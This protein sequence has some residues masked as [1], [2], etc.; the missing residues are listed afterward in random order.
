MLEKHFDYRKR[1]SELYQQWEKAGVFKMENA[2]NPKAPAFTIA[3]PPPNANGELHI[4]HSYGYSVMD[5]LGR[6]HRLMGAPVLLLPGKDHAGIQ[7]Q[8]VFEKKLRAEGVEV[9]KMPRAEFYKRCYDFCVD[10]AQYMRAQEKSLGISADWD[11]E[12]FTLD[13]RISKIVYQT[14]KKMYDDGLVYKGSRIVHWSVYSQTAISDVEVE[15]REEPGNLWHIAYALV[16]TVKQ[17]ERKSF[18]LEELGAELVADKNARKLLIANVDN[19]NISNLKA[20]DLVLNGEE[21]L[22]VYAVKKIEKIDDEDFSDQIKEKLSAEISAGG[23]AKIV[24][25]LV[26]ALERE[27]V[28][29]MATTRPETMLGDTAIAVNPED[30]R[31]THLLGK[32]VRIPIA[33][34]EIKILADKRIDITYGTGAVKVTP[35]HDFVDYEIGIDHKLEQI[36]VID[37]F[38]KMTALVPEKFRSMDI[39]KCREEIVKELEQS[40]ELLKIE[41]IKHMV[42]IAERGKDIIEPLI[43]EQWFV[44]V[45]KKGNSLRKRALELVNSGRINVFPERLK[46]TFVQWLENLR[47]WNI[48]RQILWG[49]QMPVWYKNRGKNNEEIYVD[50]EA[51]KGEGWVQE[52][53]TFDTWFSSGQWSY[54][55]FAS[56]GLLDLDNPK[57]SPYF[58]NHTMQ[59]GRDILF[60]WACRMILFA[61]YR[62]NDIPWKNIYFTGLIRDQHGQKMSKSKGNG[63]EPTEMIEKYGVDA[64]RMSFIAGNKAGVDVKFSEKKVEGYAKFVNKLWNAAKLTELKLENKYD[65]PAP[66]FKG[67]KLQSSK[68]IISELAKTNNLMIEEMQKYNLSGALENVYQF[69]WDVFCSWYL[70]IVKIQLANPALEAAEIKSVLQ[71]VLKRILIMLHAFA[72]FVTEEIFQQMHQFGAKNL[73]AVDELN[74][75]EFVSEDQKFLSAFEIISATR[76]H[77][78][79]LNLNFTDKLKIVLDFDLDQECKLLVEEMG[80]V[81]FVSGLESS[82]SKPIKA[83]KLQIEAAGDAK[84]QYLSKIQKQLEELDKI[85]TVEE[86]RL[87][88]DFAKKAPEE[89]VEETRTS[90]N[91]NKKA[92]EILRSEIALN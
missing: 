61:A 63:I 64:L 44:S 66:D 54:S 77:R 14:F 12:I 8:V 9:E 82:I 34:R 3:M 19:K 57:N 90:C 92:A 22:L 87:N 53:D 46:K 41:P 6:F 17:P 76:E 20:G 72:P 16:D 40:G 59:M 7:T 50:L 10:R 65:Y 86:G 31:Y 74:K 68:W 24:A 27:D 15:Y 47:D 55:T 91:R 88:S 28:V 26:P 85:I 36:Q 69:T 13:P 84:K 18:V 33:D 52:T 1:E 58:P 89:L 83:G 60:F 45:D 39:L 51:P 75:L 2:R 80:K 23:G 81:E 56:L 62:M 42:P 73:L 79:A 11:K 78:K 32:K 70:E 25:K 29:I 48:S 5:T 35:A 37:K 4:G 30:P 49:H 71:F 43:S 67:L 21:K 38:G